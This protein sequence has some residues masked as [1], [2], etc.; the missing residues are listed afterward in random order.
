MTYTSTATQT[1]SSTNTCT[2]SRVEAILDLVL[3]DV[4]AFIHRGLMTR[5]RALTWLSDLTDVLLLEALERF[6]IKLTLPDGREIGLDYEISDDGRISITDGCGGFSSYW[7]PDKTKVGLVVRWRTQ[8]PNYEKARKLLVE[9]GWGPGTM[10]EASGEPDRSYAKDGYGVY[11]RSIG[12][13]Q[14]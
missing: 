14:G 10:I 6:Q 8:A 4:V 11:R 13:W 5:D 9:R 1:R 3:G 7:I 2:A 12:A